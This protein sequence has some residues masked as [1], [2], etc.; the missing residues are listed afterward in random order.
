[1]AETEMVEFEGL[2]RPALVFRWSRSSTA[3]GV[4][5]ILVIGA[6]AGFALT[7]TEPSGFLTGTVLLLI[8]IAL[9]TSV[10]G[11]FRRNRYVALFTEGILQRDPFG[12]VFVPWTTIERVGYFTWRVRN[13]GVRT[14]SPV[15]ASGWLASATTAFNRR[16]RRLFGGFDVAYPIDF[17]QDQTEF[18]TLVQR[19]VADPSARATLGR[20]SAT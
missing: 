11:T 10:L 8:D 13:L 1:M 17:I 7:S 12:S 14:T 2:E 18:V 9:L 15:R 16:G 20:S 3:L 6:L 5:S 19:C 4:F